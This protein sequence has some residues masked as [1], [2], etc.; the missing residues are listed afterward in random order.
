MTDNS[1]S[2]S[3][4]QAGVDLRAGYA[5]VELMKSHV[6]STMTPGSLGDFGSFGG[7]FAPDLTG[8]KDPVLVSATDGVGTKL[9]LAMVMDKHDTVGIDCVAMSVNDIICTGAEPLFFLDYIACGR[10]FPE[11]IASIVSGVARGCRE[12]GCALVGGET[13]EHP[14]MMPEDEYDIAGFAVGLV[15]RSALLGPARVREGDAIIGL[16]SSGLHSNGFSLVRKVFEI[17]V[18]SLAAYVPGL[19]CPLGEALLTPTRLYAAPLRALKKEAEVHAACNISGGGF[20][21]NVPRMLPEGLRALIDVTSFSR[22]PIFDLL[23]REGAIPLRDM[24]NTYNMG[25]GFALC[26]PPDDISRALNTLT[27]AGQDAYVIGRVIPGE[28]GAELGL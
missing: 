16:A 7:C 12:S 14:G 9:K 3:Y 27:A 5:A 2:Q 22:P 17:S 10:I 18:E 1:Y 4:A 8:I 15:D 21:E 11:K 23:M 28:R 13:A 20:F 6:L 26:L 24:Y 25:I 19:G